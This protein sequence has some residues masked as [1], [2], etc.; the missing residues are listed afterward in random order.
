MAFEILPLE[1][2]LRSELKAGVG[3]VVIDFWVIRDMGI[4][5]KKLSS[6]DKPRDL[7]TDSGSW[8]L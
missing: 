8:K 3:N 2:E 6:V 1:N 5:K 7:L 4:K